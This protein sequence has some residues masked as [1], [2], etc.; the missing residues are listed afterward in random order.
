MIHAYSEMYVEDAQRVLGDAVE[1]SLNTLHMEPERFSM[2][3][4]V[5]DVSGQMENGNPAYVSG[6]TGPELAEQILL[7]CGLPA[8]AEEPVLHM[9]K[10][11][12]FWSGWAL[13]Y[14]Q[15]ESARPYAEILQTVPLQQILNMY[16][17][18]HEMDIS[19]FSQDMEKALQEKQQ[20]S[21]LAAYRRALG[22]SQAELSRR[23]EVPLRQIQLFEQRRRDINRTQSSCL[24]RLGK[25][26]HCRMEDLLEA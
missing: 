21:R 20:K 7:D 17:V 1:F 3:F 12:E 25:A 6:M 26:L 24:M 4:T 11:P 19:R 22:F 15:W 16:A 18:Y 13:A 23:A 10:S 9:D 14:Y 2:L 5:S 8:Y